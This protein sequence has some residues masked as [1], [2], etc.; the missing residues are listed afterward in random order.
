[1]K[2]DERERE[3]K[4]RK[5]DS[6]AQKNRKCHLPCCVA[7]NLI[8]LSWEELGLFGEKPLMAQPSGNA[9]SP[10]ERDLRVSSQMNC[11]QRNVRFKL[12]LILHSHQLMKLVN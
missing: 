12:W 10:E 8:V 7:S 9:A 3:R 11:T 6:A 4:K 1:M 5:K 2:L